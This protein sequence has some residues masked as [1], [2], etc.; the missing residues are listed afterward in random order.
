MESVDI[1]S[2]WQI[3]A[4]LQ[5]TNRWE[6]IDELINHLV[7]TGNIKLEHHQAISAAVKKR[8]SLMS[9]GIG[10]GIALPEITTDLIYEAVGALGRSKKGVNFNAV[11]N[12]PVYLV[13]LFLVPQRLLQNYLDTLANIA[14]LLL[15]RPEFRQALV[16]APDAEAM[17]QIIRSQGRKK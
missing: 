11:D 6:A 3:I 8:E 5:A 14:R 13:L 2:K 16:R 12:Q 15:Q 9:T 7:A 17:L 1:L 10:Y 4:D